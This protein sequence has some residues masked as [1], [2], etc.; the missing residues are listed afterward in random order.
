MRLW[1]GNRW[2][3]L[4]L[5]PLSLLYGAVVLGRRLAY[6][7]GLRRT[8]RFPVPV[9]VVGNVTAGGTGKTPLVIWLARHLRARGWRPG[10]VSRGYGGRARHWP[11]QVRP[12]SDPVAVGDEAVLLARRTGC[13]M[14]VGPDR[15][16]A[17]EALLEH[18]D[19]NLVLSDD[20]LQHLAMGRDLEIAVVDGSRGLGN[21]W[22]LP[23]GPLREPAGRLRRVDLVAS[24]GAWRPEVP[25]LSVS[26]ARVVSLLR[27]P[28]AG[29]HALEEAAGERVHAVAGIGNPDR[30]FDLLRRHGLEV[31]PHPFPD[32]HRFRARDLEFSPRLPVLMTEKDAVKCRRF[33]RPDHWVVE[34]DV[35]PDETFVHNLDLL[36]GE[37]EDGQETAR[38]PGLPPLQGQADP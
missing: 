8:A 38:D 23:A 15:V 24:S 1:Y 3:A 34:I 18:T 6:R 26:G 32:H 9:I 13:P 7:T 12:D 2:L 31:I 25:V 29:A 11:Q 37:L 14:C 10:I 33:A 35:E 22:L 19:C 36:L 4:P 30:F 28:E 17:V 27:G 21:G 16:A 20:G 5:L